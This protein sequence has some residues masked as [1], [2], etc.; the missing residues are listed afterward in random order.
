MIGMV[1]KV[2]KGH[3]NPDR[4]RVLGIGSVSQGIISMTG[5]GSE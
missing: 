5:A 1:V 2:V 3:V 4:D